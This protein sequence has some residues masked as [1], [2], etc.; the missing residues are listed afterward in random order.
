[1]K[2]ASYFNRRATEERSI[3]RRSASVDSEKAH[4]E[5]AFRFEKLASDLSLA[6]D[7]LADEPSQRSRDRLRAVGQALQRAFP[8]PESGAFLD[9]PSAIKRSATI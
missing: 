7:D 2:P 8:L 3:A 6:S 5:L 4:L 1:M 9:L